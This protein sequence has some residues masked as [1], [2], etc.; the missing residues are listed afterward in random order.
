MGFL[1]EGKRTMVGSKSYHRLSLLIALVLLALSTTSGFMQNRIQPASPSMKDKLAL[2]MMASNLW[3]KTGRSEI[4][5]P[6]NSDYPLGIIHFIGGAVVGAAPQQSYKPLLEGLSAQGFLVI[7]TPISLNQFDHQGEACEAARQFRLAYAEVEDYY[8]VR[9]AA[10]IPVFGLGHSLGAK[11]HVL[12]SSYPEVLAA[13]RGRKANVL[14]SFNN[15]SAKES[16]PLWG[17]LKNFFGKERIDEI[18]KTVSKVTDTIR[19]VKETTPFLDQVK[20]LSIAEDFIPKV[21]DA[22]NSKLGDLPSEFN[23]TPEQTWELVETSYAVPNTM[24]VQFRN[25]QIDQSSYLA[26]L[27]EKRFGTSGDLHFCRLDGSHITPNFQD[28]EEVAATTATA[29]GLDGAAVGR[30]AAYA[31]A[32][33]RLELEDLVRTV[34]YYLKAQSLW[35]REVDNN[36]ALQ[37][38]DT[39]QV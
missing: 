38:W 32:P 12:L 23:P 13:G 24:V 18:T 16:V 2:Q 20:Y 4:V 31:S 29:Q 15:F 17:E 21:F 36:N 30:A 19:Q 10:R 34:G 37:S 5:L 6:E 1:P 7:A 22:V 8:G 9:M 3:R 28:L 33:G 26:Q 11:L 39:D 25:D 35:E 14:L 27:L